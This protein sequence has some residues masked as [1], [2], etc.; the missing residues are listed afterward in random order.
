MKFKWNVLNKYDGEIHILRLI[1][2]NKNMSKDELVSFIKNEQEICDPMLLPNIDKAL[3]RIHLAIDNNEKITISG[4][5]DSDG[6]TGT[7]VLYIGLS[8]LNADVNWIVPHRL[9]D[10]YGI[11][12]LMIDKCIANKTKLIVT[13]DNGIS[14][15][16]SIKYANDNDIDVIVTDHHQFLSDEL[17]TEIVVDPYINEDYPFKSICGCMVAFKLLNVLIPNLQETEIYN[18]LVALTTIGTISDIMSLS[19]ENR[20]LVSNGLNILQ[21][22]SNIGLNMLLEKLNLNEKE[23]TSDDIGFG[24]GP[25]INAAGRLDTAEIAVKLFLSDDNYEANKLSTQL[26]E[27]N[28]KRKD[29]Q[30]EVLDNLQVDDNEYFIIV[31]LDEMP[32]G[33]LGI[34]AGNMVKKYHKPCFALRYDESKNELHGSGRNIYDY[35]ISKCITENLDIASGGGH[36]A[37]CGVK[38]NYDNFEEFKNRCNE[39]Y[40]NWLSSKNEDDLIPTLN[41]LCSIDF[42]YIDRKFVDNIIRLM[43]FGIDNEEPIF[44]T[45]M[46]YVKKSK[47][48]GKNKNAIQMTFISNGKEFKSI[49][50]N[51]IKD[52]Y[53]ELN[54]PEYVNIVYKIGYNEWNG[55]KTIQLSLIDIEES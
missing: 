45:Q 19:G 34:V 52:K 48:V 3:K 53:L 12:R 7:S 47:V 26:V 18:E 13:V 44:L 1:A 9:K 37:A 42:Q 11:S 39:H 25:C 27:L 22:T 16:E 28:N 23:L 8:Y 46:V 2:N 41:I 30:K 49:G 50:F 31:K 36:M 32:A 55:M 24:I 6:V 20:V 17:P 5:Y 51:D 21:H 10:G 43:P 33:L 14:S 4:D 29:L 38:L 54:S 35:D 40:S 15:H